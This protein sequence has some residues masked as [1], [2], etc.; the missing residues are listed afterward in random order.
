[1]KTTIEITRLRL[2]AFHGVLE[3]ERRVGNDFEVSVTVGYPVVIGSDEL[4]ATLNYAELIDVVKKVMAEPSALLEHVAYRIGE[5]VTSR[6]PL[7]DGGMVRVAK[8]TPPVRS[9]V[10]EVAVTL[11]W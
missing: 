5:A 4:S 1:M 3:Q 9:E 10:A 2:H 7:I 11:N 8:L 6:W